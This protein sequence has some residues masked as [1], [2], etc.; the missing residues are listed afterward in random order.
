MLNK[1]V[2]VRYTHLHRKENRV[3][4]YYISVLLESSRAELWRFENGPF[5]LLNIGYTRLRAIPI[6]YI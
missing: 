3:Q 4:L 5:F 6:I 2:T 1:V